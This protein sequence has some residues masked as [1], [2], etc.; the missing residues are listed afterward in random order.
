MDVGRKRTRDVQ[1][2][3]GRGDEGARYGNSQ[4]AECCRHEPRHATSTRTRLPC[5][6]ARLCW[7]ATRTASLFQCPFYL[8]TGHW[9]A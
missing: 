5:Q 9:V 8:A 7:T 3:E 4:E 2:G 6:R 1:E